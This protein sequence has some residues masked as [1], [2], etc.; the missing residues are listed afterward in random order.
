VLG[1][2]FGGFMVSYISAK[3]EVF[4]VDAPRGSMRRAER[5]VYVLGGLLI[6]PFALRTFPTVKWAYT[7]PAIAACALVAVVANASA[8]LRLLAVARAVTA[9]KPTSPSRGHASAGTTPA[10]EAQ[11]TAPKPT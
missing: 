11:A 2:L 9:A 5:A 8:Y 4:R 7:A 10:A 1:A 6:G 3:S